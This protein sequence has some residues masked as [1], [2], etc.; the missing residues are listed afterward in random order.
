MRELQGIGVSPGLV[1]GVVARLAP[2]PVLPDALVP[3]GD[4][5]TELSHT[6]AAFEK[7]AHEL[8]ELSASVSAEVRNIIS[9]QV[10]IALDPVLKEKISDLVHQ[11]VAGPYAVR[12]ALAGFRDQLLA[13]GGYL[14][15][16]AADLD[17]LAERVIA[18]ILGE[19]MPG[20]PVRSEPFVLVAADLSPAD[21]ASLDTSKVLAIVTE[22][23]GPT[24]HTAIIAKSLGI[25]AV[26]A[27]KGAAELTDGDDVLVDGSL[28]KVII[29]PS[30]RQVEERTQNFAKRRMA[31]SSVSGPG[32]T[33]DG[34]PVQLLVNV[35]TRKDFA[36]SARIDSEGVGLFRTEFLFLERASAPTL[37]EQRDVYRELFEAFTGRKVIVR[38]LD[39]GA[40]KPLAFV[41]AAEE[42]NPALGVRGFRT[43]ASNPELLEEQLRAISRAAASSGADV[44]V[45]APMVSSPAEAAVFAGLAHGAGLPNAGSMVEVP[46]A[47]LRAGDLIGECD[48]LSVGTNDL[49]QYTFAADRETGVLAELLD[50]WQPALL[51]LVRFAAEAGRRAGKPVGVCG[52][53]ASDPILALVLVGLGVSSLSM[54][55]VSVAP[56]RAEI[57]RH[58]YRECERLATLAL[59]AKDGFAA[60]SAVHAEIY[61]DSLVP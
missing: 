7:V 46:A 29:D 19:P 58:D 6:S 2:A 13:A 10:A 43:Y 42:P 14:A 57:A 30:L 47:A 9:A 52:E 24:S 51:E 23:G 37:D 12:D 38:T 3:D 32:R 59:A 11:G 55:P 5:E 45:M 36:A 21:T 16:R 53:A 61:G 22:A 20:I 50:P 4:L 1:R 60:R 27:C 54:A 34:Y 8:G 44:W 33:A 35:G 48:F 15:E 25:P 49:S 28:G 56:V 31:M 41:K 18:T 40:D 26:V 17:D 39:A